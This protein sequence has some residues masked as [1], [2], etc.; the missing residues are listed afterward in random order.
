MYG[1]NSDVLVIGDFFFFF[2]DLGSHVIGTE[3]RTPRGFVIGGYIL[4]LRP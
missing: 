1:Y 3:R 4:R 2:K